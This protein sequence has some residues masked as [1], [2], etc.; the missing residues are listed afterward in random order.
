MH[1]PGCERP[2]SHERLSGVGNPSISHFRPS[3]APQLSRVRSRWRC[4][5]M[6]S[7]TAI[8]RPIVSLLLFGCLVLL[9]GGCG[10]T[11]AAA[12]PSPAAV[13]V[14]AVLQQDT[15]IY[16]EFVATLDG[17]VT[18]QIRPRVSGYIIKQNYQEGSVV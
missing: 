11:K 5:Q 12:P 16:S 6:L 13:Q 10:G 3:T 14:A 15:P 1:R 9:L 2:A 7:P 8:H 17:N 4:F 18:A